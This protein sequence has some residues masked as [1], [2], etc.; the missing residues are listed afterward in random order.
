MSRN[1]LQKLI[2]YI[3]KL[4]GLGQKSGRRIALHL[5]QNKEVMTELS[6]SM[7]QAA[8]DVKTCDRCGNMDFSFLCSICADPSRDHSIICI[9]E[10]IPELWSLERSSLYK[11]LYYVLGG[12]LS[13]MNGITPEILRIEKLK[14]IVV[15]NAV[16]EVIIATNATLEGES[17]GQY[18]ADVLYP[19][20]IKITRL[21]HG[22]PMG[23]ALEYMD[24]G[25]IT[26]A[27]K[28]RHLF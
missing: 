22:I 6:A 25:T 15:D 9:V 8:R 28:L 5:L 21:A 19:Y 16:Q 7:D 24:E 14:A 18:I 1:S 20:G 3:A 2:E 23:G 12:T 27:L 4:P 17:T 13:A 11:G 10:G 26:M